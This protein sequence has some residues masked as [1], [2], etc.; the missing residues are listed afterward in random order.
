M[1]L[2]TDKH[3]LYQEY[4]KELNTFRPGFEMSEEEA[5][6][7][8]DQYISSKDCTWKNIFAPDTGE[9]VGFLIFGKSGNEKHPDT[10]RSIAEAYVTPACRRQGLMSAA[11]RDYESR[12]SCRYSLLV[13]EGNAYAKKYWQ[14]LF[15]DMGYRPVELDDSCVMADAE[16]LL[17]LGFVPDPL[18][19][20]MN[21]RKQP[22]WDEQKA[23]EDMTE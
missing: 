3:R 11:V 10:D 6:E 12:H 19:D 4:V 5:R 9:L 18:G 20:F 1:S 2:Y 23:R 21:D 17:L 13:I 14:K 22:R 8:C 15:A 7:S 16:R